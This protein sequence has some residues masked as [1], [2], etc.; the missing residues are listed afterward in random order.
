M[1]IG[2]V[3]L[4]N[5]GKSTLFNALTRASAQVADYPFTTVDK[6]VGIAEVPDERLKRLGEMMKPE[7]LTGARIQFVDIAG[8]VK[9]SSKGEGLGNTFLAHIREVDCILHVLR[10]F[11]K[12]GVAHVDGSVDPLRD[13]E[14]VST[15]LAL[16]DMESLDVRIEKAKKGAEKGDREAES[17]LQSMLE[18]RQILD[19]GGSLVA[20]DGP[21]TGLLS[22][23][24]VLYVMNMDEGDISSHNFSELESVKQYAKEKMARACAV[25]AKGELELA[26][27][28]RQ[29]RKVMRRE[30]G[31]EGYGLAQLVLESFLLL[32]LITFYTIKGPETRAWHLPV[33]S[34]VT[35]AAGKVHSDLEKGFIK[36]EVV[37]FSDLEESGAMQEVKN[38]GLMRTE[39]K[40]YIV[41]D[42]DVILV[43]F[44]V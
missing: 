9:G 27:F 10:C 33:D 12:G 8:L 7:K 19:S 39:G 4:P 43:R 29:E 14:V 3:G 13:A 20:I 42:G 21:P 35:E 38:R 40:D 22:A 37:S 26:E 36:A 25:C 23:K 5:V 15:E 44:H 28:E 31:L 18:A 6:N 41:Q 16:A 17:S 1:Q 11:R 2:I 30:L 32:N 34:R 24:P